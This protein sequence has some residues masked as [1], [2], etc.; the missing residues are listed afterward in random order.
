MKI[1][2]VRHVVLLLWFATVG[3][4]RSYVDPEL[5]QVTYA[6]I[7]SAQS[8]RAV[9]LSF[10]FQTN[11]APNA[12]VTR[13]MT[14]KVT[15][16]LVKSKLFQSVNPV[17]AEPVDQLGITIN[18][19]ADLNGAYRKG[20]I[21]G[22]TYGAAGSSVSDYYECMATYQRSGQ[23]RVCKSYHHAIHTT[24][25]L[26]SGPR[27]IKPMSLGEAADKMVQD[28]VLNLLRDLADEGHL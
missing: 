25:G 5:R 24:V 2:Q 27:G 19:I 9:Q 4:T 22:L 14:P 17:V 20:F 26:K 7:K 15:A 16:I 21:T 23:D 8:P 13:Q 3:C 18:N 28:V 1:V 11:G 12:V 6:D 10:L